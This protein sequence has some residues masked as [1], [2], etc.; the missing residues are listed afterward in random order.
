MDAFLDAWQSSVPEVCFY[1]EPK[2]AHNRNECHDLQ[3]EF[4]KGEALP[5]GPPFS[6][7]QGNH[8]DGQAGRSAWCTVQNIHM[9]RAILKSK[10]LRESGR[11]SK[12]VDC[13]VTFECD[14]SLLPAAEHDSG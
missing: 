4:L 9:D 6:T 13:V 7:V 14:T 5:Q 3:R 12:A 8:C 10:A 11:G 2:Q 1:Y